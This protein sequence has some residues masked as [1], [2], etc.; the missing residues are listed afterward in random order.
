MLIVPVSGKIGW[1]NP[2]LVTLAL[3]VVNCLFFFL[4][5]IDDDASSMAAEEFYLA[6]GLAEIEVPRYI[7]YLEA[8]GKTIDSP[9]TLSGSSGDSAI[10]SR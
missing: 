7:D 5:Q 4:F 1:K 3:L 8:T 2:P 6:S 9:V 10:T